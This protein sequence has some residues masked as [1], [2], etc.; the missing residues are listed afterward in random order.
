[1]CRCVLRRKCA[2]FCA[3]D[4]AL[5]IG[6]CHFEV[7]PGCDRLSVAEPGA[8]GVQG[9][10]GAE[11]DLA[12]GPE[13]VPGAGSRTHIDS[14]INHGGRSHSVNLWNS[15]SRTMSSMGSTSLMTQS[16][17]ISSI[18][19]T[20]QCRMPLLLWGRY[21]Q[22]EMCLLDIKSYSISSTGLVEFAGVGYIDSVAST[23]K[24]CMKWANSLEADC[25]DGHAVEVLLAVHFI[26]P[27]RCDFWRMTLRHLRVP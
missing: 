21:P 7:V 12:A 25:S 10:L 17:H 16:S 6:V 11:L 26:D 18:C 13:V 22:L 4:G 27:F 19:G 2:G 23:S 3:A 5:P 14:G 8:G 1:M 15:C 20:N 9:V 24:Y